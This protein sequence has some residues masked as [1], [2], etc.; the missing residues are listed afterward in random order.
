MF[1]F[2]MPQLVI[3]LVIILLV[4]GVG[5]LPEMG[6]SFGRAIRNFKKGIEGKDDAEVKQ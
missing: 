5:R 6:S 2:G 4:F 3:L 1:G